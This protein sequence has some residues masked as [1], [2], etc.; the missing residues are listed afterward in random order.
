VGE[1]G[2]DAAAAAEDGGVRGEERPFGDVGVEGEDAMVVGDFDDFFLE[3]AEGFGAFAVE[4]G[5]VDVEDAEEAVGYVFLAG[6]DA[7]GG[8]GHALGDAVLFEAF[9][10]LEADLVNPSDAGDED[11]EGVLGPELG[12]FFGVED[13][14]AGSQKFLEG[15]AACEPPALPDEVEHLLVSLRSG[16]HV[17]E[18]DVAYAGFLV[19]SVHRVDG[20]GQL[21]GARFVDAHGIGPQIM[22]SIARCLLASVSD[23]RKARAVHLPQSGQTA[24]PLPERGLLRVPCVREN[25]V[26]GDAAA[27]ENFDLEGFHIDKTH[28]GMVSPAALLE[29]THWIDELDTSKRGTSR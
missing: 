16:G 19:P 10:F 28:R 25:G 3:A 29:K 12:P 27:H 18:E 2:V 8:P 13:D 21:G 22:Q 23:L 6:C 26:F 17:G 20:F 5:H 1:V 14:G 4:E 24:R 7:V 11:R 9:V 15:P